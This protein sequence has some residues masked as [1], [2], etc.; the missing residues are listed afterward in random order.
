MLF[1][2]FQPFCPQTN[3]S[4]SGFHLAMS[5]WGSN[6]LT[7]FRIRG[8]NSITKSPSTLLIAWLRSIQRVHWTHGQKKWGSKWFWWGFK[9]PKP[10]LDG[11]LQCHSIVSYLLCSCRNQT[12][13]PSSWVI[14]FIISQNP[15]K[16][17]ML[18]YVDFFILCSHC[19]NISC[20]YMVPL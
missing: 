14:F 2:K 19:V 6:G 18:C 13:E 8:P 15:P 1:A 10:P 3:V 5:E 9:P 17:N 4:V 16:S 7:I 11:T 20:Y 12:G